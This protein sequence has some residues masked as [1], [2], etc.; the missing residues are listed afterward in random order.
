MGHTY[1]SLKGL[2]RS[3]TLLFS[4][5]ITLTNK[6]RHYVVVGN[7]YIPPTEVFWFE[8]PGGGGGTLPINGLMGMCRWM[9]SHFH[10]RTDYNGVAFSSIFYRVTRMG[11][12]FCRILRVR[13]IWK[14]VIYKRKD[15]LKKMLPYSLLLFDKRLPLSD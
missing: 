2:Y 5:A 10:D 3:G 11:S 6:L 15:S 7:I 14:V 8:S 9:G 13:K 4:A 1:F 12:H